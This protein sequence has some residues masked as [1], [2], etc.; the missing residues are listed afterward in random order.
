MLD[1][2]GEVFPKLLYSRSVGVFFDLYEDFTF[3]DR[4]TGVVLCEPGAKDGSSRPTPAEVYLSCLCLVQDLPFFLHASGLPALHGKAVLVRRE[5][6]RVIQSLPHTNDDR[7]AN[8]Q[9]RRER[10]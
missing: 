10:V 3:A 7:L 2:E 6:P 8:R 5:F 4:P 9:R 1:D